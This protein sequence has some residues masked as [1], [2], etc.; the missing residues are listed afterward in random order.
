MI[1]ILCAICGTKQKLR[2][3]YPQSLDF[4]K[5]DEKIF[6]ARRTPDRMHYRLVRCIN[7]GLI[8][9]N[10]ILE[11]K[12]IARLYEKSLFSYKNE[13]NYLRETY[14][15]YLKQVLGDRDFRKIKLLEI[16]CGDGFFLEEAKKLGVHVYGVEPSR[17]AVLLADEGIRKNIKVSILKPNLFKN[18][19]FNLICCFHTLDHTINPNNF[20]KIC[21]KLL[22]NG[23]L[24]L[25][26]VH[27]TNGLSV[28]LFGEKS[29]IFDIEHIYLFNSK[30]LKTILLKNKFK[31]Q[32]IFDVKNKYPLNY[33]V[34]MVPLHK[35]LKNLFLTLLRIT[36]IGNISLGIKAGN[37]GIVAKK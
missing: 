37:I 29:A 32:F 7:C 24:V 15:S 36:K 18:N 4:D 25:F 27:N 31:V 30:S 9:S 23:G 10:P 17:A 28:R 3:L 12:K 14:T 1:S 20:L 33:W 34:R 19:S 21:Y 13:S 16:G 2:Q 35:I 8:F 6:S 22:K 26:I 5:V 11:S